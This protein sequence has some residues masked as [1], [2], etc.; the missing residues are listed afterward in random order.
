MS[1]DFTSVNYAAMETAQ[2][3]LRQAHGAL[4]D[5]VRDLERKLETQL[6]SWEGD[7]RVAYREAKAQWDAAID[8]MA[9]VLETASTTVGQISGT[10]QGTDASVARSWGG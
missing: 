9:Q 7:A 1:S 5:E 6:A 3:Q 4:V 8:H 2:S 10:Y